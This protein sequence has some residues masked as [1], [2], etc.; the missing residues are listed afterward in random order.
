MIA[1]KFLNAQWVWCIVSTN[2]SPREWFPI[3]LFDQRLSLVLVWNHQPL[4]CM[5]MIMYSLFPTLKLVNHR[6]HDNLMTTPHLLS[7]V[8]WK[9]YLYGTLTIVYLCTYTYGGMQYY[10]IICH[11]QRE[12]I[13]YLG[14]ISIYKL[15]LYIIK[16]LSS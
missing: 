11:N 15:F 1:N 14:A 7:L 6:N 13:A 8:F 5:Q 9:V 4:H 12:I 10:L 2:S 16:C 3:F